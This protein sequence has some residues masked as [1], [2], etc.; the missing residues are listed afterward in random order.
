[1][2][3]TF[4]LPVHF[5]R[6]AGGE[7]ACESAFV[8]HL[9]EM[10]HNIPPQFTAIRVCGPTMS[11][12]QFQYIAAHA[13]YI[14]EQRDG[15][16]FTPLHPSGVRA[17]VF[18]LHHAIPTFRKIWNAVKSAGLVHAGPSMDV[19]Q[20]IEI[21]GLIS[22]KLQR[23][24]TIAVVDIDVRNDS[25]R[26]WK[27][28][29]S[30]RKRFIAERLIFDPL[31]NAQLWWM[32][33]YCSLALFKGKSMVEDYGRG[34]P[35]VKNF[36]DT[37][38][39]ASHVIPVERLEDKRQRLNS[40]NSPVRCVYFGRIV[41]RKGVDLCIRSIVEA[42]EKH[43]VDISFTVIGDGPEKE[44][45]VALVEELGAQNYVLFR[46]P[47]SFGPALFEALYEFDVLLAAPLTEDTPRSAFDAMAAGMAI[48]AYDTE[49]YQTLEQLGHTVV[50]TPWISVPGMA[51][52]IAALANDRERLVRAQGVARQ[53]ALENTQ[54]IWLEKR[55]T[56]T[57][58]FC[59]L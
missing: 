34:R 16:F 57:R 58:K 27:L 5:F 29:M 3:Y 45:L 6:T 10:R 11:Q 13:G 28:K 44:A 15:I 54:E 55:A 4:V 40:G 50:T 38:H 19:F 56:W 12:E 18:W 52:G 59:G 2:E 46:E 8:K 22:G 41:K 33:R 21:A 20:P 39:S 9:L 51:S 23:R 43:R 1:M 48:C 31:R 32:A 17:R 47:V 35:S 36:F 7:F 49:Y 53:I 37:A 26:A 42:R 14:N 25:T 24:K 30:N